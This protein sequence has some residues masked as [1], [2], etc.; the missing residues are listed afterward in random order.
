MIKTAFLA[1]ACA[2]L[3]AQA[4][5]EV[6]LADFAR[7]DEFGEVKISPDG[8]NL[9]A[10]AVVGGQRVLELVSVATMKMQSLRPREGDDVGDTWWVAPDRVMY[11]EGAHVGGQ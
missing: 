7:H 3:C 9:S 8:Q 6:P 2:T 4:V 1:A 10:V 5:A 11:N